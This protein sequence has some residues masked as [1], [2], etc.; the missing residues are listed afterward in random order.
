MPAPDRPLAAASATRWAPVVALALGAL[1]A[2]TRSRVHTWDAIAYAARAAGD[3]LLADRYLSTALFHP[4]HLLYAPLAVTA[5][6]ALAPLGLARDPVVPLQLMSAAFGALSAWLAGRLALRLGAGPGRALW[7][8]VAVGVSNAVWRF[9]T[10]ALV[11]VPSLA[12]LLLGAWMAA[13]ARSRATWFCAG[14][15][16]A[17][18]MLIHQSAVVFCAAATVGLV[19]VARAGRL[20]PGAPLAFALGWIVPAGMAYLA[21]GIAETGGFSPAALASWMF[22]AGHR[23]TSLHSTPATV[24]RETAVGLTE[25]WVT[26]APLRDMNDPRTAG[27][28][29]WPAVLATIVGAASAATAAFAALPG[30]A[31]ALRSREPLVTMLFAGATATAGLVAAFQPWNHAYWVYFPPVVGALVAARLPRIPAWGRPAA[32]LAIAA[33][34]AVNLV[35]R[36]L[37]AMDPARAP[38]ADLVRFARAH[39]GPGDRLICGGSASPIGEGVIVFPYVAQVPVV[40]TPIPGRRDQELRFERLVDEAFSGAASGHAVFV[41]ADAVAPLR[42]HRPGFAIRTVGTLRGIEVYRV[43]PAAPPTPRSP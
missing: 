15:A 1:Y 42:R 19:L 21:V 2:L 3:P 11:M 6:R 24:V 13:G 40:L 27:P 31:R 26:L 33:V 17:G 43:T 14:L 36:T 37:P 10:E 30:L 12:F 35:A 4:H 23:S 28:L 20:V 16:F 5:Y 8:T 29:R 22:T 9:S 41:T 34:A 39:F 7:V 25:A 38:Y 32:L 18:A